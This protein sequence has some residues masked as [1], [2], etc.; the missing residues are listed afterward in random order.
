MLLS[1]GNSL[2]F[3]FVF[4]LQS[5][6]TLLLFSSVSQFVNN[7][8]SDI[9]YLRLSSY[10]SIPKLHLH[11][12]RVMSRSDNTTQMDFES[13]AEESQTQLVGVG[14]ASAGVQ[15]GE[16]D[17]SVAPKGARRAW[18]LFTMAQRTP[19]IAEYE[20]AG[21]PLSMTDATKVLAERFRALTE[22]EKGEYEEAA[23]EDKQR[24]TR[25][26]QIYKNVHR[27]DPVSASAL[28]GSGVGGSGPGPGGL[29]IPL[30][31]VRKT[32]KLD[33]DVGNINKDA[34]LAMGKATELFVQE[35]AKR[36]YADMLQTRKKGSTLKET[37]L[38]STINRSN[39][40]R[41][42]VQ[43]FPVMQP[44]PKA[45]AEG[46]AGP[47]KKVKTGDDKST[48]SAKLTSFFGGDTKQDGLS[49]STPNTI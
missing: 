11:L 42:L 49:S 45:S 20:A 4:C 27:D 46:G 19:V 8:A 17:G 35:L 30:A 23:R 7:K 33:P 21:T 3:C 39:K 48:G 18:L 9:I 22:E 31:R 24:H 6:V 15:S 34:L 44:I 5:N 32:A 37:D 10:I 38:I 26:S 41:F 12:I 2:C 29:Y 47:S 28:G 1:R 14:S 16:Y 36:T 40:Y 25:E 13:V 43:D